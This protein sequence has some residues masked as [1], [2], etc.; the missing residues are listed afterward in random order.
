MSGTCKGYCHPATEFATGSLPKQEIEAWFPSS[1]TKINNMYLSDNIYIF[2]GKML[3]KRLYK[4][5][6]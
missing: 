4:S 2:W 1:G 3:R 6:S 5:K